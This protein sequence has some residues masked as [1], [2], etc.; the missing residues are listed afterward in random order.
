M[1]DRYAAAGRIEI[2]RQ[3][4]ELA[5][6]GRYEDQTRS[7]EM[8]AHLAAFDAQATELARL[9]ADLDS[10]KLLLAASV[11]AVT[12]LHVERDEA[13]R[14]SQD[15][16][17][18]W[19]GA[20][21]RSEMKADKAEAERDEARAENGRLKARLPGIASGADIFSHGGGI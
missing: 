19:V 18:R 9:R 10:H 16:A 17:R 3:A 4:H 14:L 12:D 20:A 8:R 7:V 5:L 13:I 21:D 1:S 2:S 15:R 11:L 6:S